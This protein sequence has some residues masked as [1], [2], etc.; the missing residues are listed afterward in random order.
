MLPDVR[1]KTTGMALFLVFSLD[2]FINQGFA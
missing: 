1:L 2:I